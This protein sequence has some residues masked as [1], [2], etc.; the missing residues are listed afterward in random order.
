[1][2]WSSMNVDELAFQCKG[3]HAY[4]YTNCYLLDSFGIFRYHNTC[5]GSIIVQGGTRLTTNNY[6]LVSPSSVPRL[7]LFI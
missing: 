2:R 7:V 6:C 1:M 5:L 4:Y 3:E